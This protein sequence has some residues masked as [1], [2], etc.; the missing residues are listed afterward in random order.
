MAQVDYF[1]FQG[2]IDLITPGIIATPGSC[3]VGNNYEVD[4]YGGYRR[5]AGYERFD[6]QASPVDTGAGN[7]A[8]IEVQRAMIGSV[9]GAGSILGVWVYKGTVYAFRDNA[10]LTAC[11]MYKATNTGWVLVVTPVLLPGGK[12]E[13]TN[14]NFTGSTATA[15]MY[16]CDGVNKAFQF[17]GTTLTQITTGMVI[18]APNHITAHKKHLF[19]SFQGGSIQHSSIGDPMTWTPITGAAELALGDECTGFEQQAG[20]ALVVFTRNQTHILYGTSA[21]DW[22]LKPFSRTTGCIA[23]T[24]QRF[25]SMTYFLDDRGVT[26]LAATQAF[27][28]FIADSISQKISPIMANIKAD[29][30]A[31]VQIR[32]K[33]QYRLFTN[34]GGG[35]IAT[36]E[37]NK[38]AGWTTVYFPNPV[39]CIVS[40]ESANGSELIYFGS[41]NG[42]IYQL[43]KGTSFD[44]QP[45]PATLR[46]QFNHI[47]SPRLRKRYRRTLIEH[48]DATFGSA[49]TYQSEFDN[50]AYTAGQGGA[51]AVFMG[52]DAAY[53][54]AAV[55]N[56]ATWSSN[57]PSTINAATPGTAK[58]MGILIYSNLTYEAAYKL[59]GA[60]VHFDVRRIDRG[61]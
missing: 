18:D 26:S 51:N 43:E 22:N 41:D 7:P 1:P 59:T 13:F 50:G 54:N 44:G 46:L 31:S 37:G 61:D 17:D 4:L 3:L 57:E 28:D 53:W 45:V 55:W 48:E 19:L 23:G 16:G 34:S 6:G 49:I 33:G 30:S 14:Y 52:S 21:I 47:K 35:V 15:S 24:N 11:L 32:N 38:L 58:N 12:Y 2:G 29:V 5:I 60:L 36:F 27:G 20:D 42:F 10:A 40:G 8:A 9:P 39:K 56:E 25:G